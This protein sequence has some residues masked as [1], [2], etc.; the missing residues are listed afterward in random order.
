MPKYFQAI[1]KK[2]PVPENKPNNETNT[3]ID[4][5][6]RDSLI[7]NIM[8]RPGPWSKTMHGKI[9][10]TD[11][12]SE[13]EQ[14]NETFDAEPNINKNSLTFD[15]E[16]T[17]SKCLTFD[18]ES[19]DTKSLIFDAD[20]TEKIS[21]TFHTNPSDKISL[22]FDTDTCDKN[23]SLS[24]GVTLAPNDPPVNKTEENIKEIP[25]E[26]ST[27]EIVDP[28]VTDTTIDI[29]DTKIMN[30]TTD[31]VDPK[32][33]DT[34]IDIVDPKLM[35][36]TTDIV[37]PKIMDTTIDKVDPNIMNFTTDI[38]DSKSTLTPE[39]GI[40]KEQSSELSSL[41]AATNDKQEIVENISPIV[42]DNVKNTIIPTVSKEA[43]IVEASKNI[44]EQDVPARRLRDRPQ[45]NV[46]IAGKNSSKG[47]QKSL[48]TKS[49][50]LDVAVSL[51]EN[52]ASES[53]GGSKEKV[54]VEN[55]NTAEKDMEDDA[56][57]V[58][59]ENT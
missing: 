6:S 39:S 35:N 21:L 29:Y 48:Q 30:I 2:L 3:A 54:T 16:L 38:V 23:S 4:H 40:E 45:R 1:N 52:D 44:T 25:S 17:N 50:T 51:K 53:K 59:K 57:D 10:K 47:P 58:I 11:V 49:N 28:K 36:I 33:M 46:V 32:I 9:R 26:T 15:A 41:P 19:T 22:S 14:Q 31:I 18:S 37:D 42:A 56:L 24:D 12:E 55:I 20:S 27:T 13:S 8:K 5:K 43:V 7:A 34:T